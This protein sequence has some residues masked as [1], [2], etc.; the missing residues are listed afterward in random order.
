MTVAIKETPPTQCHHSK[1]TNPL[2][3]SYEGAMGAGNAR[4]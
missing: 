4:M 3:L 2:M 1:K